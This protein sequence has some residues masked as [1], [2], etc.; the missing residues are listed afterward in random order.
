MTDLSPSP[1]SL[2]RRLR[3]DL[4]DRHARLD[5]G[6]SRFDLTTRAG[7]TGF[8]AAHRAAFA[9]IDPAPGG[10]T[11]GPLLA[12]MIAALDTDLDRLGQ[13]PGPDL[14]VLRLRRPMAQD[15]VLLG[16]R[17]GSQLL[18]RRWAAASDPDLRAAGAYLSLPAMTGDWQAFCTRTQALPGFGAVADE[19]VCEA[20]R[21]FD[22]FLSAGQG[23]ARV[24]L[25]AD[26][27]LSP[28][29]I[30]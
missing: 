25:A 3:T 13:G 2:R 28:E 26:A 29:R 22:L 19:T 12:R 10:L 14:P 23:A 20:G 18:R 24:A 7:L 27:C 1:T 15:Y 9:A 30:A 5:A 8:L 16:S 11:G 17:L 4:A 6:F 21:L